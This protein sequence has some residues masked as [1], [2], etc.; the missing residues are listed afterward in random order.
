MR[1]PSPPYDDFASPYV[2]PVTTADFNHSGHL[3]LAV[4]LINNEAVVILLGH[5]DGTFVPSSAAFANA[6]GMPTNAMGAADFN[7]D[8]NLDLAI[9]NEVSGQ[10]PVGLGYGDGAFSTAGDLYSGAFAVGVAAG[11][12]N[13]DRKLDAGVAHSFSSTHPGLGMGGSPGE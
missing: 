7:A 5:G 12:F 11:G 8:G 1:V 6:L 3:G 4:G 13:A 9:I 10:L 2:G